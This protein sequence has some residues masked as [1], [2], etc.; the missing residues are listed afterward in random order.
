VFWSGKV[1]LLTADGFRV[2][3]L[4]KEYSGKIASWASWAG[5][6]L[7]CYGNTVANLK[8]SSELLNCLT[9]IIKTKESQHSL[10][11]PEGMHIAFPRPH[12]ATRN[13]IPYA[14]TPLK[15]SAGTSSCEQLETWHLQPPIKTQGVLPPHRTYTLLGERTSNWHCMGNPDN[16]AIF[17]DAWDL[18]D[19]RMWELWWQWCRLQQTKARP[20]RISKS[21]IFNIRDWCKWWI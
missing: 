12:S 21:K 8:A 14:S 16:Q 18:C 17:A 6:I 20:R 4:V 3:D 13:S 19:R 10:K 2:L 1:D 9:Q 7:S 15:P 5:G 11:F